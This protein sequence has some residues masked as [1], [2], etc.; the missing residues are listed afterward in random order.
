MDPSNPSQ[1][2]RGSFNIGLSAV[3]CSWKRENKPYQ[4]YETRSRIIAWDRKWLCIVIHFVEKGAVKPR[5][6][7]LGKGNN[8][9]PTRDAPSKPRD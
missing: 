8:F 7:D 6:W 4:Q 9:G 2:A 5:S 1:P 3:Y